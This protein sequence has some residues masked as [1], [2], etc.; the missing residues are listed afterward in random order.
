MSRR[1]SI[2]RACRLRTPCFH[3]CPWC[4][5]DSYAGNAGSVCA[6]RRPWHAATDEPPGTKSTPAQRFVYVGTYLNQI[7]SMSLK[8]E[9]VQVDFHIWFRWKRDDG[10]KPLET[11]DL[12]NGDIDAKEDQFTSPRVAAPHYAICRCL[13]IDPKAMERSRFPARQ[14][15]RSPSRSK[16]PTWKR[17]SSSTSLTRRIAI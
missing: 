14:S 13:A 10:L 6:G 8:D 15:A 11:F 4:G 7:N 2:C 5:A 3:L 17:K 1:S 16:T 9:K 12:T